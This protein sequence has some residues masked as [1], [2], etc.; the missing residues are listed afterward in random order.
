[1]GQVITSEMNLN[2]QDLEIFFSIA[3]YVA[4]A[5]ENSNR[6]DQFQFIG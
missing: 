3:D 6:K 4:I 5:L 2:E 1:M